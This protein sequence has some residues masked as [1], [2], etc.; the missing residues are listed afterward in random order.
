MTWVVEGPEK[1]AAS[2]RE[3]SGLA[4]TAPADSNGPHDSKCRR[5]P[6]KRCATEGK[7]GVL[8]HRRA[9]KC[10]VTGPRHGTHDS[11]SG[12]PCLTQKVACCSSP[13]GATGAPDAT[14]VCG[15]F[16][17]F[18]ACRHFAAVSRFRLQ[19]TA[20]LL[21]CLHHP[22]PDS[23]GECAPPSFRRPPSRALTGY[24]ERHGGAPLKMSARPSI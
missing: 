8:R 18:L 11:G 4:S 24:L 12:E 7:C 19:Q 10:V 17:L 16:G 21:G 6:G 2:S 5:C 9:Q 23:S 14:L 15:A 22:V 3:V 20:E 13:G 1:P